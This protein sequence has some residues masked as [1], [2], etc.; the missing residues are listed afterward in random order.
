MRTLGLMV[1]VVAAC[2]HQAF[3]LS[4]GP[5]SAEDCRSDC[6]VRIGEAPTSGCSASDAGLVCHYRWHVVLP[7]ADG[8]LDCRAG[9]APAGGKIEAC[10]TVRTPAGEDA[11]D[12]TVVQPF[13]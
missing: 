11:F 2:A 13:Y 3:V 9:C 6:T 5:L 7:A 8:G 12:C 4:A 10:S 1:V